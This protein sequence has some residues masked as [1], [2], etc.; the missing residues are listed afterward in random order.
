M[1]PAEPPMRLIVALVFIAMFFCPLAILRAQPPADSDSSLLSWTELPDLP[2]E[3]GVAGP[4]AGVHQD[5]LI[6]A[7]GANFPPP[8][9]E[10]DKVWHD[11]LFV[12]TR[13]GGQYQW[14]DGGALPRPIAYGAAVSTPHGVVCMGGNDSVETFSDVFLL[15]WDPNTEM[16]LCNFLKITTCQ[17]YQST[18]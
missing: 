2:D 16:L 10:N 14:K 13:N 11:H 17:T 18:L 4:F 6:V 7:G 1:I 15:K 5:A 12:L 3:L 9:W 8:V